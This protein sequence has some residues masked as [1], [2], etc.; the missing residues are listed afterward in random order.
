[1][2]EKTDQVSREIEQT[3]GQLGQD[4]RELK[5]RIKQEMNWRSQFDKHPVASLTVAM[6]VGVLAAMATTR[7]SPKRRPMH[8]LNREATVA[9]TPAQDVKHSESWVRKQVS[10]H[11][12]RMNSTLENVVSA[13]IGVGANRLT[14]FL[15][16][17]LP[18]FGG[19][20]Q[21][22]ATDRSPSAPTIH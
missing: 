14:N 1:M 8:P 19:E 22:S 20:F 21:K 10:P 3:R 5:G 15:D 13:M 2:G 4:L 11:L 6:G 17:L 7:R 12:A 16:S 9:P 18:G